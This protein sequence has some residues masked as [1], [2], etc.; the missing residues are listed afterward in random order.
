M[1]LFGLNGVESSCK[2]E[3]PN[4]MYDDA[5]TQEKIKFTKFNKNLSYKVKR[6][7]PK[8]KSVILIVGQSNAA[9]SGLSL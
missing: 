3:Y 2:S 5:P 8:N 4:R 9:N 7:C 1:I 6:A